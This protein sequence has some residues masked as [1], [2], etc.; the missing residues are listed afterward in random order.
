MP[1]R[2]ELY[3]RLPSPAE[4]ELCRFL[5]L[6]PCD[7]DNDA[8][9]GELRVEKLPPRPTHLRVPRLGKSSDAFRYICLS[10]VWGT[11]NAREPVYVLVREY[12]DRPLAAVSAE[13]EVEFQ[14]TPNLATL[15]RELRRRQ[16]VTG[17]RVWMWTDQICINQADVNERNSHV[18]IMGDIYER[19]S[20]VFAWLGPTTTTTGEKI[21]QPSMD[22]FRALK[23]IAEGRHQFG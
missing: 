5:R 15:L 22:P 18:A 2:Q 7:D 10:Y 9:R 12:Q 14:I 19:C 8:L 4:K 1:K 6:F 16:R 11:Q 23:D 3:S 13:Y 20:D 21:V 17:E